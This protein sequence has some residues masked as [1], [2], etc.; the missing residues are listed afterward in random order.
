MFRTKVPPSPANLLTL[1]RLLMCLVL[2]RLFLAGRVVQVERRW[3]SR[4]LQ[5][6][7][8][9]S[10]RRIGELRRTVSLSLSWVLRKSGGF[11]PLFKPGPIA[12]M[13]MQI[14]SWSCVG[15]SRL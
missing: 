3:F 7:E 1:L 10:F 15:E 9:E 2:F 14:S 4:C 6:R 5:Q 12:A 8:V 13:Q 11:H